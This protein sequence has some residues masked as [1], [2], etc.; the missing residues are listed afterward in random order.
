MRKS[1]ASSNGFTGFIQ[2]TP[3]PSSLDPLHTYGLP[4][5]PGTPIKAVLGNLYGEVAAY[6]KTK[7]HDRLD[8]HDQ[9]VKDRLVNP[10]RNHTRASRMASTFQIQNSPG[11]LKTV[12]PKSLFKMQKFLLVRPK[13]DTVNHGYKPPQRFGQSKSQIRT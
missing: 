11:V 8:A 2:P 6:Q 5:R 1:M 3:V 7:Y 4:L 10:P 12:E 13:L 9:V